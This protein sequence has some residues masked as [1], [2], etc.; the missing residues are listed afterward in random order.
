MITIFNFRDMYTSTYNPR[1]LMFNLC[2]SASPS[3]EVRTDV[4]GKEKINSELQ[5]KFLAQIF[6]EK[7]FDFVED[8]EDTVWQLL[9]E[10]PELLESCRKKVEKYL[11]AEKTEKE[12]KAISDKWFKG[13][14]IA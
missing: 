4:F 10:N 12:I 13:S 2:A 3:L 8:S 1:T 11:R 5:R 14:K 7:F 9:G 6:D